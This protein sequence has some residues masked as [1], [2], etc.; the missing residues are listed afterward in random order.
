MRKVK[1]LAAV[2]VALVLTAALAAPAIAG[3]V[4]VGRFIEE[5]AKVKN[6]NATDPSIALESLR[7]V[8]VRLDRGMDLDKRLTEGDVAEIS[9]AA[10]LLVTTSNPF[11]VFDSQK[12]DKFFTAFQSELSVTAA[13]STNDTP[14]QDDGCS[15]PETCDNPGQGSGPGNGNGEPPFDPFSKGRGNPRGKA[16]RNRTPTNPE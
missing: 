4:T 8:G 14:W 5:L 2:A 3:D 11:A 16:K 10:G 1:R 6:L 13:A 15:P 7:S 9:R 12:V